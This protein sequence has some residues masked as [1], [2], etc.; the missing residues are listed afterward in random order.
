MPVQ[1]AWIEQQVPQCGYC[2]S[3][4]I[5]AVSALLA[6]Q[7]ESDRRGHRRTHYQHLPLRH[8]RARAPRHSLTGEKL[9][10]VRLRKWTRRAF[11]GAGTIVGGGFVLGVGAMTFAPSRHS[12]VDGSAPDVS[13]LTT[14]IAVSPDNHITVLVPHCEMGQGI[15]TAL[16]MMAAEEMDADWSLVAGQRSAGARRICQRLHRARDRRRFESRACS[17]A[18]STTAR[19]D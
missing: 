4:M 7:A 2:Q 12:V 13:Q 1:Q 16:A 8:V 11:I 17:N 3:G 19:I 9:M 15:H 18:A 10:G 5:M 14:W 6:Q